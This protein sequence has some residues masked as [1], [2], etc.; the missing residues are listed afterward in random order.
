MKQNIQELNNKFGIEEVLEFIEK[1]GLICVAIR[2]NLAKCEIYLHGA[3]V[4]SFVPEGDKEILWIS[5]HSYFE[6]GRPIR[7]GIPLCWPWFNAHPTDNSKPSH[8]F[9][10]LTEWEVAKTEILDNG[11]TQLT[12]ELSSDSN[13]LQMWPYE[14]KLKNVITVGRQ[15]ELELV[16]ENSDKTSFEIS[17]ALHSYFNISN[18]ENITISGLNNEHYIDSI[19]E[20]KEKI[21]DGVINFSG[22]VDRIYINTEEACT[23]SDQESG[24]QVTVGKNGSRSTVVWNPWVDKA[25]RMS[26]FGDDEYKSMVCV[27]T[28]NA[29]NDLITIYPGKQ[30]A[31]KA[32]LKSCISQG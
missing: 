1:N 12:L 4:A 15:L 28:T 24:R 5:Q 6:A 7:G 19:D 10:R 27:E 17:S 8:G 23:I 2:N 31:L 26:D 14:F 32:I 16:T 30:H 9:A 21:Q 29:F 3:H 18:I 20:Y 25:K 13:T 11:S 22:E